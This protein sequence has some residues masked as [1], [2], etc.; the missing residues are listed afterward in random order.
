MG[1]TKKRVLRRLSGPVLRDT[2][3]LSQRYPPSLLAMGFLVSQHGQLGAIP[4]P[5]FLSVSPL[6]EHAK[7]RCDTPPPPTRGISAILARYPVKTRRMVAIPPSAILA[8]KGIARYGGGYLAF[9]REGF[10]E[11][12]LEGG[13]QKVP[14]TPPQ[15]L[16]RAPCD[17]SCCLHILAVC[18][19]MSSS[20]G[21]RQK[22]GQTDGS[23]RCGRRGED[24]LCHGT[25]QKECVSKALSRHLDLVDR[26]HENQNRRRG[27][28]G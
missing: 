3:R 26:E 28:V 20:R 8:R 6:G 10:S 1:F 18:Y 17:L 25:M 16:G 7:W 12:F 13:V 11:G 24:E 23:H 27:S 15:P 9:K 22:D 14:R 4:P 5:P 21:Y 19:S 2:A